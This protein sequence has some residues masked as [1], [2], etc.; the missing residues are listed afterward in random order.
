LIPNSEHS[1]FP[2]QSYPVS[3]SIPSTVT[4]HTISSSHNLRRSTRSRSQPSY[5]QEYHCQLAAA[6][7]PF[8]SSSKL[9]ADSSSSGIPFSLSSY[10]SYDNLSSAQKSFSLSVSSH[11]EPRF[12][13]Q[14]VKIPHWC[15]AMQAEIDA[16]EANNTWV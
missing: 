15:D 1:D 3:Q 16:L 10:I 12:Y 2:S 4:H 9:L 11:F 6:S 14:A 5:L 13:H 8:H 7:S